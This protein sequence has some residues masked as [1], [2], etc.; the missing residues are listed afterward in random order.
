[1]QIDEHMETLGMPTFDELDY[2]NLDNLNIDE[3]EEHRDQAATT[4]EKIY[5]VYI[6]QFKLFITT[7][8]QLQVSL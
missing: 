4:S 7:L 8:A 2:E 6:Y 5:Q 3:V 1:M